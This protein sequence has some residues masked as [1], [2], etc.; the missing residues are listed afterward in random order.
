MKIVVGLCRDFRHHTNIGE[1]SVK[2]NIGEIS[3]KL[4]VGKISV[5]LVKLYTREILQCTPNYET[6]HDQS[7]DDKV[8]QGIPPADIN[9]TKDISHH[10]QLRQNAG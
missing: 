1:I 5:I 9:H 3:V 7:I 8:L 4:N 2:L 10:I 6:K